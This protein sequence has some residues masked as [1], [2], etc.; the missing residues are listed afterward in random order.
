[1]RK[2][3]GSLLTCWQS[4]LEFPNEKQ[5]EVLDILRNQTSEREKQKS[6]ISFKDSW[7]MFIHL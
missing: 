7:I 5:Q 4:L 2:E 3:Q 1:M 6:I